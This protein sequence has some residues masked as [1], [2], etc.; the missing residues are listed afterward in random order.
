MTQWT[1]EEIKFLQENHLYMKLD[2]MAKNLSRT[3]G[4][5]K[6]KCHQL[7]LIIVKRISP[8]I[9]EKFEKLTV[10]SKP[11]MVNNRLSF[12]CRCDCEKELYLLPIDWCKK[13]SCGCHNKD[14][15][16]PR[17]NGACPRR[18]K[19]PPIGAVFNNFTVSST[20]FYKYGKPHVKVVCECSNEIE[21]ATKRLGKT[22]YC[23][24]CVEVNSTIGKKYNRLTIIEKFNNGRKMVICVC[25][26][27]KTGEF[28]EHSVVTSKTKSCGCLKNELARERFI[29]YSQSLDGHSKSDYY[30]SWHCWK[31][32]GL[33]C[34]EWLDFKIFETWCIDNGVQK[35]DF[36]TRRNYN[37]P[38]SRDNIF[39]RKPGQKQ[40]EEQTV[41]QN[42]KRKETIT[43]KYGSVENYYSDIMSKMRTTHLERYGVYHPM[44][45]PEFARKSIQTRIERHPESY[46]LTN[47]SIEEKEV[48]EYANSFGFTFCS[49]WDIL[50]GRQL[51]MYCEE[52]GIA[53]EYN[54]LYYHSDRTKDRL[55]HYNKFI[56]CL[57]L[58][59]CL[60][61]IWSD[62]WKYKNEFCR[63][64]IKS[65][66]TKS[67]HPLIASTIIENG[68][69]LELFI[70]REIVKVTEPD[71]WL[72]ETT[73]Q[74]KRIT[75]EESKNDR[76][77][78]KV[79]NAGYTIF[80]E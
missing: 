30:H 74:S 15:N 14:K 66:I 80:K 54:G 71:Y 6:H 42:A 4:S 19:I 11:E 43:E 24:K 12:K 10:I 44:H 7:N 32:R 77:Y 53:I 60:I 76:Q 52:L 22:T 62:D 27:G 47:P 9:G 5:V 59:I 72:I 50:Y 55:Y 56:D 29:Q 34:D 17:A 25:D 51:D 18:A 23:T 28:L 3:K 64:L 13:E 33:L 57:K 69:G 37:E 36:I 45:Y 38:L 63:Q 21:I 20:G 49:N 73:N 48:L 40:L 26:C 31:R 67:E 39:I 65:V 46:F 70:N 35:E 75:K 79:W 41:S 68:T 1:N 61:F 16:S 78:H 58:G 2:D 8:K